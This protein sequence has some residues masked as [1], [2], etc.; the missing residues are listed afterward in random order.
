PASSTIARQPAAARPRSSR[1]R[2]PAFVTGNEV[3]M[4][5]PCKFGMSQFRRAGQS[6]NRVTLATRN[7]CQ[8]HEFQDRPE[9]PRPLPPPLTRLWPS[10]ISPDVVSMAIALI[11]LTFLA[12]EPR[13]A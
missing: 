5:N 4:Q 8:N 13:I 7:S 2:G 10:H 12:V 6:P 9:G 1:K 3:V 11:L